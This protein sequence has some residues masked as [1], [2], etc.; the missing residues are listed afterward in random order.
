MFY[1]HLSQLIFIVIVIYF[2]SIRGKTKQAQTQNR[3]SY[4]GLSKFCATFSEYFIYALVK[5]KLAF[6]MI[7]SHNFLW[8][9]Q[10]TSWAGGFRKHSLLFTCM[11]SALRFLTRFTCPVY[12]L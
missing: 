2:Y 12:S 3:P 5:Q 11:K 4:K 10:Q 6:L 1:L 8:S 9:V 7:I